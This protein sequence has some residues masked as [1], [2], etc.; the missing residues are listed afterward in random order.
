MTFAVCCC[1]LRLAVSKWSA[2]RNQTF[3]YLVEDGESAHF[4]AG[5]GKK[6]E[7]EAGH[8]QPRIHGVPG[9]LTLGTSDG[10]AMI[11]LLMSSA[12][13]SA[14]EPNAL[15]DNENGGFASSWPRTFRDRHPPRTKSSTW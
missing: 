3:L 7:D 8:R 2:K 12:K 4:P 1:G 14:H 10:V 9:H 6:D 13:S 15:V 5:F 11:D